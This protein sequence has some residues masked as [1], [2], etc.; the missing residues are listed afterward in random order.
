MTPK[1][2]S[3]T[4]LILLAQGLYGQQY[5][6]ELSIKVCSCLEKIVETGKTGSELHMEL[7]LCMLKEAKAY[8][9]EL[10]KEFDLD[11]SDFNSKEGKKFGKALGMHMV[12]FCP[13]TFL[14][15][16]DKKPQEEANDIKSY[17]SNGEIVAVKTDTYVEFSIKTE[18][19]RITK[20]YWIH[21]VKADFDLVNYYTDLKG[22]NVTVEY[23]Q[24]E[25][26]DPRINEYRIINMLL[27]F[28][29]N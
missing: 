2:F 29:K 1:L 17:V 4:L 18:D 8:E 23:E 19:D 15:L 25:I 7:G 13:E 9:K 27:G 10:K 3:L 11:L 21:P 28:S 6:D 26:F 14:A 20:F 24:V 22:T 16:T 5:M 12:T